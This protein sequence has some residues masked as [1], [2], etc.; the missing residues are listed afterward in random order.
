MPADMKSV[1]QL[2]GPLPEAIQARFLELSHMRS[3]DTLDLI[4]VTVGGT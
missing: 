1:S 2:P 4:L 3:H